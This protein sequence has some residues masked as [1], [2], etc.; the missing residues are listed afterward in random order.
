LDPATIAKVKALELKARRTIEGLVSGAHRSPYQG[1]SVEFAEHRQYVAGDDTRHVD[2]KLLGKTDRLFIKRYEQETNL[3]ANLVID[4]SESMKYQSQGITKLRYASELAAC[5][6][7]LVINKQDSVG[8]TFFEDSIRHFVPASGQPT[9]LKQLF[10]LLATT[11]PSTVRS[12]IGTVLDNL[13]ERFRKRSLVLILSDCFGDL[14]GLEK[15][16]KHLRYRRHQVVVFHILDAAELNFPFKDATMFRGLEGWPE[17]LADPRGLR[18]AYLEVFG[19]FV[20]KVQATC[21]LV[22][23]DYQLVRTDQPLA[24]M[25]FTFLA[26]RQ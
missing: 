14:D 4:C 7:Y 24:Q 21:K 26:T 11:E 9:Q 17:L 25:L 5:L 6:A 16:L 8:I 2:W 10:H 3:I 15:G 1:V 23:A 12:Q 20:K 19:S 13:A 18:K 22:G